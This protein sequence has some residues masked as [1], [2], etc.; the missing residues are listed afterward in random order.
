MAY[1]EKLDEETQQLYQHLLNERITTSVIPAQWYDAVPHLVR[2][3]I[4]SLL[5]VL[6]GSIYQK[7]A[8]KINKASISK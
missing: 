3:V 6:V 2:L 1:K 7:L 8:R 4:H 5:D